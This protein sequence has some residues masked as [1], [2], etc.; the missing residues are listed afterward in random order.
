MARKR[1][2]SESRGTTKYTPRAWKTVMRHRDLAVRYQTHVAPPPYIHSPVDNEEPDDCFWSTNEE[3][4][5]VM[6]IETG[7]SSS[8]LDP[9]ILANAEPDPRHLVRQVLQSELENSN[10]IAD[11]TND[12]HGDL[13]II[14]SADPDNSVEFSVTKC[15]MIELIEYCDKAGTPINFLDNFLRLLKKHMRRGFDIFQVP[16][17][18][19]FME[20]LRK[21]MSSPEAIP[22]HTKSGLVVLKYPFLDQ[23]KDLLSSSYAQD[24]SCCTV[25]S[26]PTTRWAKYIPSE[27]EGL[28]EVYCA[29][30]YQQTHNEKIGHN[31]FHVHEETGKK[32]TKFLMDI[33]FYNDKTGVG[34]ID[35]KYTL[36]PLMFSTGFF[37]R[38][39]RQHADAWRH[40]GFIPNYHQGD[41]EEEEKDSQ[42]SL[43]TF[44]EILD[45][46]L[47]DL[48]YYQQHPP[49]LTLNLFGKLAGRP[50]SYLGSFFYNW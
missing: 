23:L 30:W 6:D 40:L 17:R 39:V 1:Y 33:Q 18:S 16:K 47:S 41:G 37:R 8:S 32:Y 9:G 20:H 22:T 4:E 27:D 26:N 13:N 5:L 10:G 48:V 7:I 3:E 14:S 50:L 24:I 42:R 25:N 19:N 11:E 44:H 46:F 35:G 49:C 36:E 34:A 28:S 15:A 12:D 31:P 45:V 2:H 29:K 38:H 21:S 43:A